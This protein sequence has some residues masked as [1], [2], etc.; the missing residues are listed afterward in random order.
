MST[1][2]NLQSLVGLGVAYHGDQ[3]NPAGVGAIVN[4]R[5][6]R[7]DCYEYARTPWGQTFGSVRYTFAEREIS[8]AL[9]QIAIDI[10]SAEHGRPV[11]A[12]TVADYRAGLACSR[13]LQGD[14]WQSVI[15]RT[16]ASLDVE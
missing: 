4:V 1:I 6:D 10:V 11:C 9:L 3:A 5:S 14:D 12:P 8:D 13:P 2:T 16:A 15:R 7:W